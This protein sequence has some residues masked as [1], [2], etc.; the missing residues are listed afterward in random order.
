[1][2]FS[3]VKKLPVAN[4]LGEGVLWNEKTE[5]IWWTD[6]EDKKLFS[7]GFSSEVLETYNLPER[8]GSFAMMKG[9]SRFLAAFETGLAIYDPVA[10]SVEW[11]EK[12]YEK[13]CGTR[14]NDGRVDRQGQFWVGAM[15]EGLSNDLASPSAN[16]FRFTSN[17]TLSVHETDIE[18]SNSLCWSPDGTVLYFADSP[19]NTIYSYDVLPETGDIANKRV[20]AVTKPGVHPDGA[21]VDSEGHIWNA[22]WGAGQVVRYKPNGQIDRVLEVPSQQPTCVS[23]GGPNLNHLIITSARLNLRPEDKEKYPFSGALFIYET[24]FK[25]LKEQRFK[26]TP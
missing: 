9:A 25:G 21:C 14:M 1:M 23:F 24:S 26:L 17:K 19:K 15:L 11:L 20:F 2:T 10:Q 13:G 4:T 6:I 8:L 5:T 22:Q 7:Y 12:I 16:L 3:L 18:I